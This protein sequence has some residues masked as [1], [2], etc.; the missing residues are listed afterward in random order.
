MS[1][2]PGDK[3]RSYWKRWVENIV[4]SEIKRQGIGA[5]VKKLEHPRSNLV[6]YRTYPAP[7]TI[8]RAER[9]KSKREERAVA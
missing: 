9:A 1:Y 2:K 3:D 5:M 4:D 7:E 6:Q 8:R